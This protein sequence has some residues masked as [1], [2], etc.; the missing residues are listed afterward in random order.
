MEIG[1]DSFASAMYGSTALSSINAMEQ[2]LERIIHGR[3]H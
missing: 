3:N 2:L 1:I